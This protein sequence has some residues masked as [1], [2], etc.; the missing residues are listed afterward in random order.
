MSNAMLKPEDPTKRP[1]EKVEVPLPVWIDLTDAKVV[2]SRDITEAD[3]CPGVIG[4]DGS[5]LILELNTGERH[6]VYCPH[7]S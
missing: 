6:E 4:W 3:Y 2:G 5:F 7:L 1:T